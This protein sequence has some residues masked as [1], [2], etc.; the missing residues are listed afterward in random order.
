M[1][2]DLN[3]APRI[4]I[5]LVNSVVKV[6]RMKGIQIVAY[7]DSWLSWAKSK[8]KCL[9]DLKVTVVFIEKLGFRINMK[10]SCIILKKNFI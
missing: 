4:F 5:K 6:R 2:F 7:L 8:E 1:P 3:I 10:K 9:T